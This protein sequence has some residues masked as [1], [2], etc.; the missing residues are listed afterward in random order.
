MN[1]D[2][3]EFL[4]R[5]RLAIVGDAETSVRQM[6]SHYESAGTVEVRRRLDALFDKLLESLASQDLGPVLV[7]AREIADERFASGYDLTEVQSAFS[8]LEAAIWA[9]VLAELDP[10]RFAQ[11]LGLVS[12]ILGAAK[13]ALGREYVSLATDAHAPS[14]DLRALFA[15]TAGV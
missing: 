10:G 3:I 14:L 6:R 9:H 8:T 1:A 2:T 4:T 11:T 15:G 13:D 7:L 12:T 5:E